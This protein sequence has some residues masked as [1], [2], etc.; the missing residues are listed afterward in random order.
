M[1][2]DVALAHPLKVRAIAEA[3]IKTDKINADI[4]CDLLRSNL[5]LEAY[6]PNKE[7][8]EAKNILRQRTFFVRVQTMVKNHIYTILD[9][10]P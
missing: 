3:R 6:I 7:T 5:L 4:L 1:L 2:D 10:Q 8:W 9:R